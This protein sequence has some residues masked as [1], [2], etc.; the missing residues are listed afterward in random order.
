MRM[1][2]YYFETI[3]NLTLNIIDRKWKITLIQ[4]CFDAY[5]PQNTE[6]SICD[7]ITSVL[8]DLDK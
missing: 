2:E 4:S 6:F 5:N 7:A 1:S 3:D 8:K